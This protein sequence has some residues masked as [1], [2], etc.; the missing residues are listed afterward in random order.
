MSV[1]LFDFPAALVLPSQEPALSQAVFDGL[2][3]RQL[4]Q[5]ERN[6]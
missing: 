2:N 6:V 5:V 4:S 1:I 3:Y